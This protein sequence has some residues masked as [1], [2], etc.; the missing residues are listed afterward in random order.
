MNLA[1]GEDARISSITAFAYQFLALGEDEMMKIGTS[2]YSG[3]HPPWAPWPSLILLPTVLYVKE[4][5]V[6]LSSNV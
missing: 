2:T 5:I 4:A 3:V 6:L 1:I